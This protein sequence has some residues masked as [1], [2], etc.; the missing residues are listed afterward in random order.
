M[1]FFLENLIR[2][3]CLTLMS[4]IKLQTQN[5]YILVY[6]VLILQATEVH[7]YIHIHKHVHIMALCQYVQKCEQVKNRKIA[8][9]AKLR[10]QC[11][12]VQTQNRI[13]KLSEYVQS[14]TH[15]HISSACNR[16]RVRPTLVSGKYLL[17]HI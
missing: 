8:A 12:K 6:I 3:H 17:T 14:S 15:T 16:H 5:I 10:T 1:L 9:I 13:N 7:T 11:T 2:L 4:I